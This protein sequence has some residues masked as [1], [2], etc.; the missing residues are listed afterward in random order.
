M[1]Y[2]KSSPILC[3]NGLSGWYRFGGEAG[4]QMPESCV[5][6]RRCGTHASGW[7]NGSHPS[8]ADETVRRK[9]CFHWGNRCC[10]WSTE[11]SVRNCGGFFV[12][13]LHR[14]PACSLRYC[15]NGVQQAPGTCTGVQRFYC[16]HLYEVSCWKTSISAIPL[17]GVVHTLVVVA[18]ALVVVSVVVHLNGDVNLPQCENSTCNT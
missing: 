11:I 4:N 17:R 10:Q 3:D 8:V 6:K 5:E 2:N 13:K 1:T 12:Y 14:P 15:G 9:V 7:L 18:E 16:I